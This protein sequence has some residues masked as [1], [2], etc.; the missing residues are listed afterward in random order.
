MK[1][2]RSSG[3]KWTAA[4]RLAASEKAKARVAAQTA[5]RPAAEEPVV[6]PPL[7]TDDDFTAA[8]EEPPA[9]GE[10]TPFEVFLASL[11]AET[12]ELVPE[13][14]LQA[15]FEAQQVKARAAKR[16]KLKKAATEKA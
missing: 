14:E 8:V 16:E 13:A 12:R 9:S 4:Q 5:E 2:T 1:R 7:V 15:I 6:M 3:R 10:Q 11:D